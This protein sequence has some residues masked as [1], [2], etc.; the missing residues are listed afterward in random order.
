[1]TESEN[2]NLSQESAEAKRLRISK[3]KGVKIAL[4]ACARADADSD[5]ERTE[6]K[7]VTPVYKKIKIN[8]MKDASEMGRMNLVPMEVEKLIPADYN[9]RT[10]SD[11]ARTGLS[12]SLNAFGLLQ[13]IIWNKQTGNIVGGHQRLNDLISKGVKITDVVVVDLSLDKEKAL[14]V[15]LNNPAISGVFTDSIRSLLDEINITSPD[16]SGALRLDD[17][18]QYD[19]LI[20]SAKQGGS[21]TKENK[22]SSEKEV[23]D[24]ELKIPFLE[25]LQRFSMLY[26]S[27]SGGKDSQ[28]MVAWLL[29]HGIPKSKMRLLFNRTPMDYTDLDEHVQAFSDM[30][31]IPIDIIGD[32]LTEP[33]KLDMFRKIGTPLGRMAWCTFQWKITPMNKYFKSNNLIGRD[34][35]CICQ[36]WRREE[37]AKRAGASGRVMHSKHKIRLCRPILDMKVGEVFAL[38]KQ[39]GWKLHDCYRYQ[40]RLGCIYCPAIKRSGWDSIR[41]HAPAQFQRCMSYVVAGSVSKNI[42][43]EYFTNEVR[44]M[45]GFPTVDQEK[46]GVATTPTELLESDSSETISPTTQDGIHTEENAIELQDEHLL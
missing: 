3:S 24:E 27:F 10:M 19:N 22:P 6:E 30:V 18:R 40:E 29:D 15:T 33:Q 43:Y 28:A 11:K 26:V 14:N 38:I 16:L 17:I 32:K 20:S 25:W 7:P 8:P 39:H 2:G 35:I 41:E 5:D 45:Y 21:I 36:G 42:S 31:G 37:A 9:P 34:D 23:S 1:M 13:P 4:R 44:K 12:N 46:R